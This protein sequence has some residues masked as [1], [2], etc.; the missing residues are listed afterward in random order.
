MSL[1]AV[2]AC[3]VAF[4][5]VAALMGSRTALA[6]LAGTAVQTALELFGAP[7]YPWLW[8]LVDLWVIGA[9]V[10]LR[11]SVS[12][13]FVVALFVPAWAFYFIDGDMAY[14]GSV[15]VCSGQFLLAFPWRKVGKHLKALHLKEN[16]FD[17]FD[18]RARHEAV[19]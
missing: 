4:G 1:Q 2:F 12:D 14:A 19:T 5:G 13:A 10:G 9:I 16:L 3:A 17:H 18:L 7:F 8:M 15:T 11:M 6:L